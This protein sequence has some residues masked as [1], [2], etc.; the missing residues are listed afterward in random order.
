MSI[1]APA[2]G[3]ALYPP[4]GF[5]LEASNGYAIHALSFDGDPRGQHDEIIL[6]V[7]RK[8]SGATYFVR[9]DVEVTETTISADLGSLGS[10]DLQFVPSGE[11]RVERSAC[12][13]H[14]IEFDS[15]FYEGRI[16]FEGEERYT[17]AH[18]I[19]ARGEIRLAASLIC[20]GGIDEGFGGHA[21]G[22]RLQLQRRWARGHLRLEATKNSATRPARFRASIGERHGGVAIERQVEATAGPGAF[23][24]D[25]QRQ[26]ALLKPPL[27]F[28][29][30]AR[31]GPEQART[32][33]L[34]GNLVVDF[35]GNSNV[36]LSGTSG[37]LQRWVG[38]PSHPFRPVAWLARK[39]R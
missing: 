22:A 8:G 9:R 31:F 10:I 29:G 3:A 6:F 36:S 13:S 17:E 39:S 25:V 5:R 28:S 32:G 11:P 15:G 27:P 1:G 26:S 33:R 21:P 16:D 34:Q 4:G 18:R 38:N 12:D 23:E 7:G 35:S 30:S 2:V 24:F 19:R 37:S 14:P 20:V